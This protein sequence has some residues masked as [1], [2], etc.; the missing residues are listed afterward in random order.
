MS[1]IALFILL[2]GGFEPPL[3][4]R[5][6]KSNSVDNPFSDRKKGNWERADISVVTKTSS[7]ERYEV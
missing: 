6:G 3:K 2:A 4:G 7:S 5:V 1:R